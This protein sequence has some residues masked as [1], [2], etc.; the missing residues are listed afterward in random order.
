MIV[1]AAAH[2]SNDF[3]SCFRAS[4][5]NRAKKFSSIG[6]SRWSAGHRQKQVRAVRELPAQFAGLLQ[7]S[8]CGM[9]MAKRIDRRLEKPLGPN[10]DIQIERWPIERLI[11]RANNPRTHSREQVAHI[12]AFDEGMGMGKLNPGRRR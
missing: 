12:A 5:T 1:A 3:M 11:P 8:D 2:P 4:V 9:S 6:C 7:F 10:I